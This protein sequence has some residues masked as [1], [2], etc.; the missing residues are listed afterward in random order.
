M[1]YS[2]KWESPSNIALVKYWGKKGVQLP[3]NPSI[4]FTL[5][6][7]KT[8]TKV[9]LE[10]K[11]SKNDYDVLVLYQGKEVPE[12]EGKIV[13]FL[14]RTSQLFTF[15]KDYKIVVNTVNTFPHSSGIASSASGLSALALCL[16]D[17]EEQIEGNK[18]LDFKRKASIAARLGSGSACRSVYGGLVSW[19]DHPSIHGSSDEFAT[20]LSE[21]NVFQ[22]FYE[23]MDLI[24]IVEEGQKSV[25]SSVGH[26]L[27][28]SNPFSE[29]RYNQ[30]NENIVKL[31]KALKDGDLALFTQVVESEALSLHALMMTS[32]PYFLLMKPNTLAIIQKIWDFRKQSGLHP[33]ITLDAGAN[34][35]V[36]FPAQEKEA[37]LAYASEQLLP[38]CQNKQYICST[39]GTGPKKLD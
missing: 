11:Q 34:V 6:E 17:I 14:N 38:L 10:E 36:L 32:N 2:A 5:N 4:S 13:Q 8:I 20:Q 31:Q 25:S 7:A 30:A 12:F 15:T 29:V 39:I 35:H 33:V 1:Q 23:F 22:G 37:I 3:A 24:L 26:S 18:T 28:E 19:G 9:S 16:C 27:L 21:E